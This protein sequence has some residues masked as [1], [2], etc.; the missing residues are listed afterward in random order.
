M[1]DVRREL[2]ASALEIQVAFIDAETLRRWRDISV[3]VAAHA[4]DWASFRYLAGRYRFPA[5]AFTT[6]GIEKVSVWFDSSNNLVYS[7]GDRTNN[8]CR[9]GSLLRFH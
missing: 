5:V 2:A 3:E 7:V 4:P 9:S 1:E 8:G 6:A